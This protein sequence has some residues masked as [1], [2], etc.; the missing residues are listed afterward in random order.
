M[1]YTDK[2]EISILNHSHGE[3]VCYPLVLLEGKILEKWKNTNAVDVRRHLTPSSMGT[4]S[5]VELDRASK[6][7]VLGP[8]SECEHTVGQNE[9]EA[10]N[11]QVECGNSLTTCAVISGGF[12]TV[13]PLSVGE[14]NIKL[15]CSN[16]GVNDLNF[17][18]TYAPLETSRYARRF[19]QHSNLDER[20]AVNLQPFR[21]SI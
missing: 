10:S 8:D 5:E 20:N 18:M 6:L 3:T 17:Q 15:S 13:V 19:F 12:K 14:N 7:Q 9:M 1:G 2:P 16:G 11:L 4:S 21:L